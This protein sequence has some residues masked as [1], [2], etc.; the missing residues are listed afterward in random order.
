MII[1]SRENRVNMGMS[2]KGMSTPGAMSVPKRYK[3]RTENEKLFLGLLKTQNGGKKIKTE[4]P[5]LTQSTVRKTK[6]PGKPKG[7]SIK[8][9]KEPGV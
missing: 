7:W 4:K 9:Q 6:P 8:R 1:T 3:N 2:R 5:K